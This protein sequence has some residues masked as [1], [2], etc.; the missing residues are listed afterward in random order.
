MGPEFWLIKWTDREGWGRGHVL[1]MQFMCPTRKLE[2]NPQLPALAPELIGDT[3]P[4]HFWMT[5]CF[6]PST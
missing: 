4:A 3:R 2:V 5:G 1:M 6:P